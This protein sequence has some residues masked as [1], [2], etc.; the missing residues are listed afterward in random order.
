MDGIVK[1]MLRTIADR[2]GLRDLSAATAKSLGDI[3]SLAKGTQMLGAAF[4]SAGGL[5]GSA[6]K[7]LLKGGVWEIAA[8]GVRTVIGLW[9]KHRESVERAAQA[10]K[11]A[12]EDSI[13][14]AK[15]HMDAIAASLAARERSAKSELAAVNAQIEATMKLNRAQVELNRNRAIVAAGGDAAAV[16]QINADSDAEIASLASGAAVRREK[17]AVKAAEDVLAAR[18][19]TVKNLKEEVRMLSLRHAN[20]LAAG[21]AARDP[22][23][24]NAHLDRAGAMA[25]EIADAQRKVR[26]AEAA[27]KAAAADLQRAQQDAEAGRVSRE[28]A[29]EKAKADAEIK[30]AK[31]KADAAKADAEIKAAKKK[32]FEDAERHRNNQKKFED[33]VRAESAQKAKE[34]EAAKVRADAA[35]KVEDIERN[36]VHLKDLA[37]RKDAEAARLEANAARARGG[38]TFGEWQR[39]ERAI[40]NEN[41]RRNVRQA[42]VVRNAQRE[43]AQLQD[44][45]RRFGRGFNPARAKRLAQLMEFVNDQNPAN[46]PAAKAAKAARDRAEQLQKERDGVQKAMKDAL[47]Q[48]NGKLTD[49]LT[50]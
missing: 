42:N 40:A 7:N 8:T 33:D 27:V 16:A 35:K 32:A 23:R 5:I 43:I 13:A 34:A 29:K 14:A 1:I 31:E 45:R 46:N 19:E 28:A 15:A 18:K 6:V 39:G 11:K 9:E 24:A 37:A 17:A 50:I 38:K 49:A 47:D 20:A 21:Q 26:D 4:G 22:S 30:A 36:I 48:I 2:S 10:E 12:F 44:E 41:R 25:K 3:N